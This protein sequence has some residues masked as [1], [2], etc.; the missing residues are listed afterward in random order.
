MHKSIIKALRKVKTFKNR[1]NPD[2]LYVAKMSSRRTK[3]A[4]KN[5]LLNDCFDLVNQPAFSEYRNLRI[6]RKK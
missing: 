2:K 1:K 3:V 5:Y 4:S 6:R